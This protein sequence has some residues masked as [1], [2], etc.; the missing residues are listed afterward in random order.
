MVSTFVL[1]QE[2][3]EDVQGRAGKEVWLGHLL[4]GEIK[5]IGRLQV[6]EHLVR[7]QEGRWIVS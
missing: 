5:E 7:P 6:S 2:Q 1:R 3:A 4:G